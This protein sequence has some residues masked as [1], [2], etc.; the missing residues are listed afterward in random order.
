MQN[1]FNTCNALT[2]LDVSGFDTSNVKNMSSM[3]N[4]CNALTQLDVSGFD[5]SNVTYM[6]S[7][8]SNCKA[9]TELDV[10]GFNTINVTSL[11]DAFSGCSSLQNL[12]VSGWITNNVTS[13]GYA[14]SNCNALTELDVSG[15]NVGNATT[16]VK[17]SYGSKI[18]SYVGGRTIDEV[19]SNNIGILNGLKVTGSSIMSSSSDRASLRALINGV[20]DLTGQTALTLSLGSTLKAKLTEEDIAVATAKNWTIS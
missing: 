7:M 4:N 10:S 12:D 20:A 6:S 18:V 13:L 2:E 14:F 8:F 1:M 16:V 9:L 11:A 5:T 19:I 17:F 3:F 15:W